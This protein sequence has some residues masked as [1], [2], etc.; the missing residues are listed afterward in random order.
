MHHV[1][2]AVLRRYRRF[3][4]YSKTRSLPSSLETRGKANPV[5]FLTASKQLAAQFYQVNSSH[6]I[7]MR[8]LEAP[9]HVA[10]HE[11]IY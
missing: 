11:V 4:R 6:R 7:N 5:H 10:Y 2:L 3:S 1:L 9:L 8:H